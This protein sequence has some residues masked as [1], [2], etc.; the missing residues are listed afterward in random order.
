MVSPRR[1]CRTERT[2]GPWLRREAPRAAGPQGERPGEGTVPRHL[3]EHLTRGGRSVEHQAALGVHVAGQ[4]EGRRRRAQPAALLHVQVEVGLGRASRVAAAADRSPRG[5]PLP[6]HHRDAPLAQVG[7]QDAGTGRELEEDVVAPVLLQVHLPGRVVGKVAAAGE[8]RPPG[9]GDHREVE[10]VEVGEPVAVAPEAAPVLRPDE[11]ERVA[12]GST[13]G[14][15]P[16]HG[17]GD[18]HAGEER[19]A[20]GDARVVHPAGPGQALPAQ[21]LLRPGRGGQPE[22]GPGHPVLG[23]QGGLDQ[24]HREKEGRR[25]GGRPSGQRIQSSPAEKAVEAITPPAAVARPRR[26]GV[27]CEDRT[28]AVSAPLKAASTGKRGPGDPPGGGDQSPGERAAREREQPQHRRG[29]E[30][31]DEQQRAGERVRDVQESPDGGERGG[32]SRTRSRTGRGGPGRGRAAGSPGPSRPGA[33]SRRR[34]GTARPAAGG[35]GPGAGSGRVPLRA[36]P[37][38]RRPAPRGRRAA[39]SRS[40]MRP[41]PGRRRR[42]SAPPPPRAG[43]GS[44][45]GRGPPVPRRRPTAPGAPPRGRAGSPPAPARPPRASRPGRGHRRR[46]GGASQPT[47]GKGMTLSGCSRC[48]GIRSWAHML[49]RSSAVR[50]TLT[51]RSAW[52]ITTAGRYSMN[53]IHCVLL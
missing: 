43:G 7:Q 34:G 10:G 36:A 49:S 37:R 30:H 50:M 40:E 6:G 46:G 44:A 38:A 33:A 35:R 25:E 21:A 28:S 9:R 27:V 2:Q 4:V 32:R 31:R 53:C 39:R 16:I 42:R 51:A 18:L 14:D 41:G 15:G 48:A 3:L 20:Q 17:L 12:P 47:A 1:P 19:R 45:G 29:Q 24:P 13:V 8:H 11:V 22:A 5:E 52:T 23:A 26:V